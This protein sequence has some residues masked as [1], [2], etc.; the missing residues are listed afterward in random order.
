MKDMLATI[1]IALTEIS[2]AIESDLEE[3]RRIM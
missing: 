3:N 2:A 1:E